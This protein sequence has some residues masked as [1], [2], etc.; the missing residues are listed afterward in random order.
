M[1]KIVYIGNHLKT[2]NPTTLEL[3]SKLL[4]DS[5]FQVAV[6]SNQRLKVVRLLQMCWGV[7]K[8]SNA[9]YVLID[10][11]STSNF[12]YALVISQLAR[13]LKI[14]YVPILHGGNLPKRLKTHPKLAKLV[15]KNAFM[16]IAPSN[17]LKEV[18]QN[19]NFET[20]FIPNGI[21]LKKYAFKQRKNLQPKLL[22]VRAFDTIYNP[23]MAIEVLRILKKKY[24]KATL[25]MVGADKDGTLKKAKEVAAEKG[26]SN[27]IV[28]TG[29]L[30]KAVWIEMSKK[31]DIFINT[32]TVDNTPVS[33][34]EAMALGLPI[35]STNVGGIPFLINEGETGCL[36]ASNNAMQMVFEIEK[37]LENSGN[38]LQMAINARTM[39]TNFDV[40]QVQNQ[41]NELLK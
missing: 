33:V 29:Y 5:G 12:Y 6:Y 30:K 24:P 7:I 25:C 36:V 37:L 34:V 15:F 40:N 14:L 19:S 26:L 16:N 28:F 23:F 31:H 3:L 18:F 11:Y 10:T 32:T 39:V 20:Q 17:Y 38:S 1:K 27:A 22:W 13:F 8:H 2:A 35:V 4:K 9:N 41:W 21:E